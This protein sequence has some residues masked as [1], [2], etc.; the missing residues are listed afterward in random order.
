MKLIMKQLNF[1]VS[2]LLIASVTSACTPLDYYTK[3]AMGHLTMLSRMRPIDQMLL[4]DT[5][6]QTLKD[7]L[8]YA[9]EARQFASD[10]LLLPDN[11][12]YK[13]YVDLGRD[14]AN[15]NIYA[16]PEFD[17]KPLMWCFPIFGCYS[18]KGYFS[19]P[20]AVAEAERLKA[21]GFDTYVG[22]SIAFSTGGLF[23]DPIVS[24]MFD[25]A[26]WQ[27]AGTLFHELAHQQ[28]IVPND[29]SFTEAFATAV[30]TLGLEA[31]LTSKG[32]LVSLDTFNAVEA[33]QK[34]FLLLNDSGKSQ[35][36]TLYSSDKAPEIKRIEKAAIFDAMRAE[37]VLLTQKWGGPYYTNWFA[38][39]LNNAHLLLVSTYNDLV[40]AFLQLFEDTNR[41]WSEFYRRA[42]DLSKL[43]KAERTLQLDDLI[44]RWNQ[45]P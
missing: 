12:S 39:D 21:R 18:F 17:L 24:T 1:I 40:P 44:A 36:R 13:N 28:L 6:A 27:V 10:V 4:D 20:E 23:P 35:L 11:N 42:I 43:P 45:V 33:R 3:T 22:G 26:D 16:T 9:V 14:S 15:Y 31:W 2:L 19:K 30:E 38:Q 29:S 5:V 32:D 25:W 41:Q 37:Q 7:R 8:I 34:D